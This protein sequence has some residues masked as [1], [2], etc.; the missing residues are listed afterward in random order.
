MASLKISADELRALDQAR[1]R[2]MQLSNS[3][4]SLKMDVHNA[5]PLPSLASLHATEDIIF[6]DL[7][8]LRDLVDQNSDLFQ[9]L[10]VHPSTNFP[11]RTHE[12]VLMQLIRKK[13]EPDVEEL[14]D[15][16]RVR[17]ATVASSRPANETTAPPFN[18]SAGIA[19]A[20]RTES[21]S[22]EQLSELRNMW[23]EIRNWLTQ[24]V[25]KYATEEALELFTAAEQE[26]GEETVRTGLQ[27]SLDWDSD[28]EEDENEEASQN[29]KR[30]KPE[31][32]FVDPER[33]LSLG[34]KLDVDMPANFDFESR[35]PKAKTNA[36]PRR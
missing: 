21:I 31:V 26:A 25:V 10:S 32:P 29:T 8:S 27:H 34:V 28:E 3:I 24:R 33:I 4:G 19:A 20:A 36:L 9:R 16:G 7:T 13:L 11:G 14:V 1:Q 17:G 5:N 15:Q 18:P 30:R 23:T 12:N 6:K 22:A 35:R 2:F